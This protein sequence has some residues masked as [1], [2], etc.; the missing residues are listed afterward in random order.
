MKHTPSLTLLAVLGASL[1]ALADVTL[2]AVFSDHMVLQRDTPQHVW[3]TAEAGE[4][5]T[6]TFDRHSATT[7]ADATGNWLAGLPTLS[8]DRGKPHKLTVRGNN[9]IVL[10]NILIGDVWIGS[11]QSNMEWPLKNTDNAKEFI[12][13]AKHSGIRLF[14]IP[15]VQA[16]EP[17][18]DVK[19]TWK[20]CTP[21][22]IPD[23]SAVLYHF[24]KELHTEVDVP[25]GLI[26]SSWGGSAIEPWTITEK[27]S[28]KMYNGMIAPI[29]K[30]PVRGVIWYQGETNVIQKNGLSYADKMKDLIRGWRDAFH[31]KEMPFYFVQIAP[32]GNPRYEDGQLPALWEA[33][34]ATLKLPHTGMAVI[35][36][37]VG[38]I[39]DIHPRN[40]HDVGSR[41]ARWA[42]AKDYGKK[43]VIYSGPLF[44]AME[45]KGDKVHLAFAHAAGGLKSR[46]GKP[47][48]E[49]KIAGADG[50]FVEAEAVIKGETVVVSAKNVKDP[51]QVRFGWH[52]T[53][54]PNLTNAQG[55]PASPFQTD[56]W[57]GGTGE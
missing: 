7:T 10:R 34:T 32:W 40:K 18:K 5:I 43:D 16:N 11:G 35:T 53:A 6:V 47:L 26:N 56:N 38:N 39:G 41:L 14:H 33:Q 20:E 50:N 2:P 29:V 25:M 21:E 27:S 1:P 54:N 30:F 37:L 12:A 46:D 13:G 19:A 57:T 48:T 55:L 3:G 45:I 52:R 31:N 51:K 15:K 8:A 49:F 4:K 23:F 36:D 22:N 42:L 24:G 17:A 9:E 28:G 44:K